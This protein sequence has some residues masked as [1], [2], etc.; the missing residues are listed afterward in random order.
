MESEGKK[1]VIYNSAIINK[2]GGI[3]KSAELQG[4]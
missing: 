2:R 3:N 1:N 4:A